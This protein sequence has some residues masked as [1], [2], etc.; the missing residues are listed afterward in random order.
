MKLTCICGYKLYFF[1]I[2]LPTLC[3][4]P[5]TG[6]EA[7]NVQAR[8]I[9]ALGIYFLKLTVAHLCCPVHKSDICKCSDTQRR[10]SYII[11]LVKYD[12]IFHQT[13]R[14]Q[15]RCQKPKSCIN[16]TIAIHLPPHPS[17]SMA[18]QQESGFI[19]ALPK[20]ETVTLMGFACDLTEIWLCIDSNYNKLIIIKL[21]ADCAVM[22]CTDVVQHT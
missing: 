15:Y 12:N 8:Y 3:S 7:S 1:S 4:E 11:F 2:S 22:A 10:P 16:Y 9:K 20:Q 18:N 6:Y 21:Y 14:S 5:I 13:F 17:I 19:E